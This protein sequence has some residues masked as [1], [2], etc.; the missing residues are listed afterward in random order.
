MTLRYD[1]HD[2]AD[3]VWTRLRS[4]GVLPSDR[5][6]AE[7]VSNAAL[8]TV[9]DWCEAQCRSTHNA[10]GSPQGTTAHEHSL[11]I[12]AA[13]AFAEIATACRGEEK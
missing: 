5:F 9:A 7:C 13:I 10:D 12:G 2:R 11:S 8:D 4:D 1:A 3:A 6:A